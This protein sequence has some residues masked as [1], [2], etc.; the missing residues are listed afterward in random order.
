LH[1]KIFEPAFCKTNFLT[2]IGYLTEA[3]NVKGNC[4]KKRDFVT[5]PFDGEFVDLVQSSHVELK[6]IR[7][8]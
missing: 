1:F 8:N 6:E 7:I 5:N 3:E 2:V 4:N